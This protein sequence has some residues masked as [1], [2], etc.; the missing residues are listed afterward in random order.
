MNPIDIAAR[1]P[2]SLPMARDVVEVWWCDVRR[3]SAGAM[4][5]WEATLSDDERER[6]A[7]FR[8]SVDR[9]RFVAGRGVLRGVVAEKLGRDP[10]AIAFT[11]GEGGKPALADGD[12]R[13]NLSRSADGVIVGIAAGREIG[14]DLERVRAGN[15]GDEVAGR[16]FAPR[17]IASLAALPDGIRSRGFFRFWTAKEAYVKARGEGLGFPLDAFAVSI[18]GDGPRRL[19]WHRDAAERARWWI[20]A[21][22]PADPYVGAVVVDGAG[23][24]VVEV[25][26]VAA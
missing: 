24:P 20:V 7:R 2:P 3:C 9:D 13:F 21:F 25:R 16:F 5:A 22:S 1:V 6:A 10:A 26:E 19:E 17:E 11:R 15:V 12:L 8:F 18:E 4:E 14:V 23:P